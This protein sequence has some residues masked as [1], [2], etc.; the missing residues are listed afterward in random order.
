[1]INMPGGEPVDEEKAP[2]DERVPSERIRKERNPVEY[3]KIVSTVQVCVGISLS[4]Q[5]TKRRLR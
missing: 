1:M 4:V 5:D 3:R 2:S